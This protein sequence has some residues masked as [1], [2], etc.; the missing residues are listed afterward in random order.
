MFDLLS[1]Q[2]DEHKDNFLYLNKQFKKNYFKENF[3]EEHKLLPLANF[4]S[5]YIKKYI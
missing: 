5:A 3:Y 1:D 4:S 2:K